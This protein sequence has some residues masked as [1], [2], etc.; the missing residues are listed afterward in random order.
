MTAPLVW[1]EFLPYV[2]AQLAGAIAGVWLAHAMFALPILQASTRVRTGLSL[3]LA[4]AVATF[5]LVASIRLVSRASPTSVAAAGYGCPARPVHMPLA[6]GNATGV[7]A[8]VYG[9]PMKTLA[10]LL[11]ACAAA[12]PAQSQSYPTRPV[13]LIVAD[14]PGSVSDVRA[15]LIAAKMT[16]GLG[17]PVVIE[18]KPGGSMTIA[19]EA[20]ATAPADGY[21]LFL[22]NVVTH[23]LN[24]FLFKSLGYKPEDLAPVTMVSAGPLVL[25][26][27]PSVPARS[28]EELAALGRS[29]P[30]KLTYGAIGNGSPGHLI[31]EQ[32]KA[33]R[34][35]DFLLVPYKA[36][37]QYIQDQIAGHVHLSL[38]YWVILGPHVKAGRL[39]ALAVAAPRRLTA[40]PEIPTFD[41]AGIPG[42][43][44]SSW[45]G[46]MVPAATPR[47]VVTRLHAELVRVLNL[48]DV[49]ASIL[50]T[51]SEIGGN[52]PEEFGAFIRA[53]RER[54]RRAVAD[55][56]VQPQ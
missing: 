44:G 12:L 35:A 3:W 4:E 7:T 18:N 24:P 16:E 46:I 48:P 40:A 49:R 27:H 25:V 14:G 28:L 33:V 55:A 9:A 22:G 47:A 26:V 41:E 17:Q 32:V 51:G 19:A 42:V 43:E 2:G 23:S 15:R 39:R 5:G 52:T 45:Q 54:W 21:T 29:Q 50:D 11:L 36:T 10:A 20:A 37:G 6:R 1:N 56:K 30:G 31:M 38:N 13:K 8:R 34:G 53:D